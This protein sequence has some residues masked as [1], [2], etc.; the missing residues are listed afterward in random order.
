M[1]T[2]V[3]DRFWYEGTFRVPLTEIH[4]PD[5]HE[6]I[7]AF[8]RELPKDEELWYAPDIFHSTACYRRYIAEWTV[9]DGRLYLQAIE[10]DFRLTPGHP[11]LAQWFSG[12]VELEVDPRPSYKPG[13]GF[14]YPAFCVAVKEGIVERSW[15]ETVTRSFYPID[16]FG[17]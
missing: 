13:I 3:P 10:G 4:L 2:Q 5:S 9:S 6:R 15:T 8:E 14:V 1:T 11:L 17:G 12:T 16:I 7:V